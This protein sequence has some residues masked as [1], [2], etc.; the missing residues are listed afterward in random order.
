MKG[1]QTVFRKAAGK[2]YCFADSVELCTR[3]LDGGA[4]IIQLR[5]KNLD[6]ESFRNLAQEMQRAIT[7]HAE[8]TGSKALL[9]IN[10]RSEIALSL[11]ADGIHLGQDDHDYHEIIKEAPS[12]MIVGVSVKT[13]SQALE[14]QQ[15]GATYVG[16]GAVFSTTTKKD[17]RVIGLRGLAEI[18][19][20]VDIPVVA[21]GG[22]TLENIVQTARQGASYFAIISAINQATDIAEAIA[23][24][25]RE[26]GQL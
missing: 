26:I 4:E 7:H 21:I 5:A 10:D 22:I 2:L 16:A 6:N 20:A 19:A 23:S 14:A 11:G 17:T 24:F 13:I 9:I 1:H 12:S 8:T 15:S 3:L 25:N 18:V